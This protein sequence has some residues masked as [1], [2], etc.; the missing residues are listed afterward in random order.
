MQVYWKT[1]C[2]FQVGKFTG[3]SNKAREVAGD[4]RKRKRG[5]AHRETE[6]RRQRKGVRETKMS[7]FYKEEHLGEWQLSHWA[8]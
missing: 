1:K 6:R 3:P 4:E 5:K 8:E 2:R 7:G